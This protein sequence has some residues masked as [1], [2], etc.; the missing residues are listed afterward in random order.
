MKKIAKDRCIHCLTYKNNITNDHVIPKSWYS[1]NSKYSYKPTAPACYE[2]NQELGKQEKIISHLMWMC[3]PA[4]HLLRKELTAKVFRACGL[5]ADGKPLPELTNK[6]R[7]IRELY[8]KE[9]LSF[10]KS[11]I[12]AKFD[13]SSIFPGFEYHKESSKEAQKVTFLNAKFIENIA[14]KVVRGLEYIQQK[15]NRY[16]E[17]PYKLEVYFPQNPHESS[18]KIIREK[19]PIFSDG[20]NSIQ[21]GAD[22]NKPLE[23]VYIIRLW[24]QW[25][26]WGV[27]MHEERYKK[28]MTETGQFDIIN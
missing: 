23:P 13:E 21:R 25:E 14:K 8:R 7:C 15:R 27:I 11:P 12:E 22:P 24:N 9:L 17:N 19:S 5:T 20:T 28:I 6:E 26:I 4:S 2:C 1:N 18:L 10:A 16:I 3:I